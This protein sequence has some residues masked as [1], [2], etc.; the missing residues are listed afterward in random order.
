MIKKNP[1]PF[2]ILIIIIAVVFLILPALGLNPI[3]FSAAGGGLIAYGL[4]GLRVYRDPEYAKQM[5][6]SNQDERLHYIADKSRSM[7]LNIVLCGLGATG[8]ILLALDYKPYGY[9]CILLMCGI[10]L[11]YFIIYQVLSRRY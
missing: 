4:S 7:T 8:I 6:I 1:K 10:A 11:L 9:G 3:I 5:E 2:Y